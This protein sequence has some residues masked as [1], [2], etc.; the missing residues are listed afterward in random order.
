MTVNMLIDGVQG[1]AAIYTGDDDLPFAAPLSYPDRTLFHTDLPTAGIVATYTV[2]LTTQN[3]GV[4]PA[5]ATALSGRDTFALLTHGQP[6]TPYVEGLI[7]TGTYLGPPS[8][9]HKS[10]SNVTLA[11]SVPLG[12]YDFVHLGADGT[13]V[14]LNQLYLLVPGA[15]SG[16]W[17]LS[18]K[19][20][21]T[22]LLL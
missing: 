8:L 22:D 6:G 3:R 5:S 17:S 12:S 21:I 1:K 16:Y 13:N 20:F 7:V 15:S 9:S 19:I 18:M 10:Q 14:Y 2:S 11:G 4:W